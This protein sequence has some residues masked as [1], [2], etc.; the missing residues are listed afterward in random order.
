MNMRKPGKYPLT[1]FAPASI[2]NL[3]VGFDALGLALAPIDGSLLGD[4]VQLSPLAEE[5]DWRLDLNGPFARE[6]PADPEDNIVI[7]CCRVYQAAAAERGVE[8][9]PLKVLLS[10]RL[11]IG[12]GLGSSASSIVA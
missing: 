1:V 10:K 9:Q 12:S 3:S 4:L 5:G 11:P 6:L 2:G 7:A 8:I